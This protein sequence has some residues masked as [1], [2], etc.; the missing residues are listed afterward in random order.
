MCLEWRKGVC[1]GDLYGWCV[2]NGR[3]AGPRACAPQLPNAGRSTH[4]DAANANANAT[5]TAYHSSK[6]GRGAQRSSVSDTLGDGGVGEVAL[7]GPIAHWLGAQHR[8]H[9]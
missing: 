8:L 6:P 3:G 7:Q 1:D 9:R 4:I 2:L 5:Q